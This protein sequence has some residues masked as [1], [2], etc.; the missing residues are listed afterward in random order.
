MSSK[1]AISV[2]LDAD[3]IT[4]LKG[5]AGA[6]GVRS[7]SELLDQIVHAA[8]QSGRVGPAVS[9]VGTIDIDSKDPL[10]AHADEVVRAV[11]DKS[12]GRALMGKEVA[13]RHRIRGRGPGTRRRG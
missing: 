11:F 6:T 9:V 1:Q 13:S 12:L 7:V 3:N 2:T 5:R 10:L 4:W 8:R